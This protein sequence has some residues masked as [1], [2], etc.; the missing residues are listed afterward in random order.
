MLI[1]SDNCKK[2]CDER[3]LLGTFEKVLVGDIESLK[4]LAT[5]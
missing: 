3:W 5:F 4:L 1:F 2:F